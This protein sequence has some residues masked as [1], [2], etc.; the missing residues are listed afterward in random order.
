MKEGL[1]TIVAVLC[2]AMVIYGLFRIGIFAKLFDIVD[3]S[4]DT[5]EVQVTDPVSFYDRYELISLK[6]SYQEA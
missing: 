6:D 3:A 1:G 2:V 4:S 5:N